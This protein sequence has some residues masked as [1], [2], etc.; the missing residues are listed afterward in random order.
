M[1][2]SASGYSISPLSPELRKKLAGDLTSAERQ[3]VL[4]RGRR[5]C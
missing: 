2:Q 5:E 1:T 4:L 3:V